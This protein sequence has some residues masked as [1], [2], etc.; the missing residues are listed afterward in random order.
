MIT[1]HHLAFYT[2]LDSASACLWHLIDTYQVLSPGRCWGHSENSVL[3]VSAG[4][5]LHMS[6]HHLSTPPPADAEN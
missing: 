3:H 4:S 6:V 2:C 1:L 5:F